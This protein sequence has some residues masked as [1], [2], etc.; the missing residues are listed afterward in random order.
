[1]E[2]LIGGGTLFTANTV[3]CWVRESISSEGSY[4]RGSTMSHTHLCDAGVLYIHVVYWQNITS[5][6][7]FNPFET[8][9]FPSSSG[10]H[11]KQ[12]SSLFKKSSSLFRR[13]RQEPVDVCRAVW[14]SL[15]PP[16]SRVTRISSPTSSAEWAAWTWWTSRGCWWTLPLLATAFSWVITVRCQ[17]WN[18]CYFCI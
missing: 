6:I 3:V 12:L 15:L 7:R 16:S 1:M 8:P 4:E 10:F 14:S 17:L 5:I 9:P 2:A 11:K 13:S 18:Y